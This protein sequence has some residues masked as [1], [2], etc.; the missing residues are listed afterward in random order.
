MKKIYLFQGM[1][2]TFHRIKM[3]S[4][5]VVANKPILLIFFYFLLIFIFRNFIYLYTFI[6]MTKKDDRIPE[7]LLY[8]SRV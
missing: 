6:F 8:N 3:Q 4:V 7:H 1:K 2:C 5:L